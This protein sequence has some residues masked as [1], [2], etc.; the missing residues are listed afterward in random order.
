V[1]SVREVEEIINRPEHQTILPFPQ[2]K[3]EKRE[4]AEFGFMPGCP[5]CGSPLVM[6]EGC[7]T[8]KQCGF[9]RCM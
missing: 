7:I 3:S 6:S 9:N 2:E 4:I 5:E 1:S 8:C